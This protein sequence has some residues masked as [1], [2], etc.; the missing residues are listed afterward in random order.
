MLHLDWGP[1]T[2]TLYRWWAFICATGRWSLADYP[3]V[4]STCP[5]CGASRVDVAH[6]FVDC[7]ATRDLFNAWCAA[8]DFR[9][10]GQ[11]VHWSRLRLE[12]FADRVSFLSN[13]DDVGAA[14]IRFVGLAI[15]RVVTAAT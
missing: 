9:I 6:L 3:R 14:R 15:R 8:V 13:D 1:D 4:M 11:R 2:W 12:L 10:V 7:Q 5:L